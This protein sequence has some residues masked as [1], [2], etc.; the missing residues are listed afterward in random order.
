MAQI[1]GT[2]ADGSHLAFRKGFSNSVSAGKLIYSPYEKHLFPSL[3]QKK[4]SEGVFGGGSHLPENE[5]W[6]PGDSAGQRIYSPYEGDLFPYAGYHLGSQSLAINWLP[7]SKPDFPYVAT[8]AV[9][10][11]TTRHEADGFSGFAT[12]EWE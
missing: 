1:A 6:L 11:R 3:G 9:T 4:A 2:I 12:I 8:R 7:P 10:R 5:G